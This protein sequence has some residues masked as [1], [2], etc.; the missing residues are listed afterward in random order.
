MEKT[1][2]ERIRRIRQVRGLT[3][4]ELAHH[5]GISKTAMNQ[6]ESSKT[7]DPGVSRVTA[8]ARVLQVSSDY[9]LGLK[10]DDAEL[11]AAAVA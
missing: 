5:I 2:G 8:I 6:I 10:E 11:L 7:S 3:Q 1:L 9:L 4:T